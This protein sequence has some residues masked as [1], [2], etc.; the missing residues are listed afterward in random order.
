[1][2]YAI[3]Y[4]TRQG[5][6]F[7]SLRQYVVEI[8]NDGELRDAVRNLEL[9]YGVGCVS[10]YFQIQDCAFAPGLPCSDSFVSWIPKR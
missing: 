10:N 8:K 1:M 3:N 9:Q 5:G 2:K 4:D 7:S 6:G